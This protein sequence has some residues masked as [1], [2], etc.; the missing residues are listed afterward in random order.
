AERLAPQATLADAHVVADR[1]AGALAGPHVAARAVRAHRL[2]PA[3]AADAQKAAHALARL[4]LL[5]L[6]AGRAVPI[7]RPARGAGV[8]LGPYLAAGTRQ[9]VHGALVQLAAL[10]VEH[11]PEGL[12]DRPHLH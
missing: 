10:A 2:H 7:G 4:R 8:D 9:K 5:A 11:G 12:P 6:D 3:P 1:R